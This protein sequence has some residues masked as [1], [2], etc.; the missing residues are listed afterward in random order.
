VWIPALTVGR[1]KRFLCQNGAGGRVN[2]AIRMSATAKQLGRY[3]ILDELGRGAMGVVYKARDPIIDRVVALKTIDFALTG[4]AAASFEQRFFQEARAAGR[5]NH[6]NIVTIYDAGQADGVAYIAMEFLDG[7]S[8]R[9]LLDEHPPPGI[10]RAVEVAGQV[11]RGLAYAHEQGV[12]HRDIKPANIIVL[13]NRRPKITDFGIARLSEADGRSGERAGSPKYMAPEQIRAD[14]TIDGRADLFSLG[15]VLYEMLTGRPPFTGETIH[16]IMEQVLAADPPRP[17]AVN[18]HV[19]PEL[20]ALVMRMLAKRSGDRFPSARSVFRELRR[21]EERLEERTTRE[22]ADEA[23]VVPAVAP[24][25]SDGDKTLVLAAAPAPPRRALRLTRRTV[26]LVA[27]GLVLAGLA[28][29]P[30]RLQFS[31]AN[32]R[33][34]E[35]AAAPQPVVVDA[36]PA[37]APAQPEP[38]PAIEPPPEP[39]KVAPPPPPKRVAAPRPPAKPPAQKPAPAVAPPAQVAA[40]PP[41]KPA[42]PP[43]PQPGKLLLNVTPRGDVYI[44]G[45]HAGTAPPLSVIELPPGRH[46]VEIRNS[47]QLP[48]LGYITLQAGASHSVQHTFVE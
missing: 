5:L 28:L 42:A 9:Q 2:A 38:L 6:P 20:D 48:Y 19:P 8:L 40:A 24:T 16:E 7:T 46:K 47:T 22:A 45:K 4:A 29:I 14:A 34:T 43:A 15:A 3:E 21:I 30:L 41:P 39:V 32:A 35:V 13:R 12:I 26:A 11:A 27:A 10:A 31:D 37:P 33:R 44:D 18:A 1:F 23:E 17:G 36:V 25:S